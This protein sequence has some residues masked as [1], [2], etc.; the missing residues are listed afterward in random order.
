MTMVT[1]RSVLAKTALKKWKEAGFVIDSFRYWKKNRATLAVQFCITQDSMTF[2]LAGE[3]AKSQKMV[4]F[5]QKTSHHHNLYTVLLVQRSEIIKM[6]DKLMDIKKACVESVSYLKET[7]GTMQL[8]Y[9]LDELIGS[10]RVMMQADKTGHVGVT[11]D[12]LAQFL[13]TYRLYEDSLESFMT[14]YGKLPDVLKFL[15]DQ[16]SQHYH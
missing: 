3:L 8:A 1:I 12:V 4:A 9:V 5:G 11:G 13:E 6:G 14:N 15:N 16:W 7:K 10:H 2:S